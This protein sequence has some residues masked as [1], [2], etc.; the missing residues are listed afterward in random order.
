MEYNNQKYYI[1]IFLYNKYN[2]HEIEIE[3]TFSLNLNHF[4]YLIDEENYL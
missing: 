4:Y 1:L 2:I 3:E